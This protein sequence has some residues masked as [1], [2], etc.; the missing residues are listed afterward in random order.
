MVAVSRGAIFFSLL[1]FKMTVFLNHSL[2]LDYQRTEKMGKYGRIINLSVRTTSKA[3]SFTFWPSLKLW[4]CLLLCV[5][6]K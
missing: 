3:Y 2:C 6:L 4:S 5:S 1:A